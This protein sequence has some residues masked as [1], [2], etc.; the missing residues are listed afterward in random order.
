MQKLTSLRLE[1]LVSASLLKT[2][3]ILILLA[4]LSVNVTKAQ[5]SFAAAEDL[6]SAEWG[7]ATNVNIGVVPDT[8]AP[9]IAGT[10]PNAPLWYRWTAPVDG[11]VEMD[12]V[13]SSGLYTNINYYTFFD[14]NVVPP[15][16]VLRSNVVVTVEK[17]DTV[18]G[19]YTGNSVDTLSQIAANDDLFPLNGSDPQVNRSGNLENGGRYTFPQPYHGPSHLRFNAQGGVSYYFAVDSKIYSAG[20]SV[21]IG[22]VGVVST[23]KF[24]SAGTNIL[25]WAYKSSGIFRFATENQD[26]STGLPLYQAADTESLPLIGLNN[27]VNSTVLTYYQYNA[28]GVLVTVT[29][30]AGSTGRA[31]VNYTTVDGTDLPSLPG[32]DIPAF[33]GQDYTPVSGTLVFDDFE[34][35]KT[36]LIPIT[37]SKFFGSYSGQQYSKV[38]GI[39]LIDDDGATSPVLDPLESWE[40]SPPRVDPKFNLA[41]VQILSTDAD[42]Y[43]P[44]VDT[45]GVMTLAPTNAVFNFEKAC[46][47]VPADVNDTNTSPWTQVTVYVVRGGTNKEAATL[48]YRV[49]N[50]LGSDQDSGEEQNILFPL[51]PGS[52]Y[53]VPTPATWSPIR[54]TNSDFDMAKGTIS[55]P[56]NGN[57]NTFQPIQFSVPT[58][59]LTK[60]NKDFKIQLYREVNI[61]GQNEPRLVGMVNETTVTILFNDLNPPAGSV[62]ELYNADFN[63]ELAIYASQIPPTSPPDNPN[64]GVGL[65]GQVYSLALLPNNETLLG[66]DFASYN[67]FA[68]NNVA[69]VLTNGNLDTTF[70]S[71]TGANGAVNAVSYFGSQFYIGGDFTSYNGTLVGHVA[72][73]NVNGSLDATFNPGLG[74]DGTIRALTVLPNGE[75][76]IGGDFT[77]VNGTERNFLALLNTDGTLD[78][79]FDPASNLD[80]PVYTLAQQNGQFLVGGNFNVNGQIYKNIVRLNGD[81]S[82]DTTFNSGTGAN[83]LVR[84]F[85]RMPGGQIVVGGEFTQING[86]SL[87][88]IA[89]LNSD[90]SI[91][92]GF[93]IG[94]AADGPVFNVNYVSVTNGLT[95]TNIINFP[96]GSTNYVTNIFNLFNHYL[97][98]G[99]TF[100]S[101]NGTHRYG[102]TRLYLD[103]TVDTTFMDTAYNQF[104]G[105]KRIYSYDQPGV[106]ASAVQND[107]GVLIGGAFVQVGGGQANTNVCNTLDG[108]E[109]ITPSFGDT[110][111]W[112]EPKTRDG[113]RNRSSFA[114]LVGGATAGPGNIGL[115]QNSY[116]ANKSQTSLGISLVRTNGILGPVTA[117]FSVQTGTAQSGVDYAYASAPPMNWIAWEYTD[118]PSRVHSDGLFGQSG[119]LVDPYGL[120]L[121]ASTADTFLNKQSKVSISII[122]NKQT[123]GNLNA[124]FQLANPNI[125]DTFYL[126]GQNIPVGAALGASSATFTLVDDTSYPGQFGFSSPVFIATNLS[127][128]ISV[129]RSNGTFGVVSM[130]YSSSNGTAVVG[131]DYIG[132]TNKSLIFGANVTSNGFNVTVKN[133]GVIYTNMVEKTVN[134]RLFNIGTTPGA[135]FG[136]SNAV[137]RIINP[138]YQGYVTLGATNYS[139]ALSSGVLNFTVN[140]ISGSLGSVT[141]QYGTTNGSAIN[142]T[143]YVGSTNILTWNNGDVS[144]RVV[145]IPLINPGVVGPNKQ[146]GVKLFN[147][148]INGT[149]N[150]ALM[151]LIPNASLTISN[152]NNNGSIQFTAPSYL[153]NEDGGYATLTV[154]RTGG[155][156]GPIS[157]HYAT[158]DGPA[159]DG[160]NYTG[161]NGT[162]S[163]ASGQSSASFTVP[164]LNDGVPNPPPANFYFNVSLIGPGTSSSAVVQIADAQTVIHPP[165]SPDT[166]FITD[167]MNGNVLALALQ[168]NGQILAGGNFTAVGPVAENRLARL[169]ADG[170]LDTAFLNGLSGANAAVNT[171]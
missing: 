3:A 136:I 13:G 166:D 54:G 118:H 131:T 154:V 92:S 1:S 50:V 135:T 37:S 31:M 123:S 4:G 71:G 115:N 169:N 14:T 148:T 16:L 51:Q 72:R 155:A 125:A 46:Y 116:S 157:A 59:S 79:T 10:P 9:S 164:I 69:L 22:G 117:N 2:G 150:L 11:V 74:A 162:I 96:P 32:R 134:L 158:S 84:T 83:G 101:F 113:V 91:D 7:G 89:R 21:T 44:D 49:N 82:V 43:G 95:S 61:G 121:S 111:L 93:N 100:S 140:R 38:F 151:G 45:N 66:G 36:I 142:G 70:D 163:L 60:F 94:T 112:V 99:G 25:H 120:S 75:V 109:F 171:L 80:G 15:Q 23:L 107:G 90:G 102:F 85:A 145:S 98:V 88:H 160:I 106:F 76:L 144:P 5:D 27:D 40:V 42:P 68:R 147:P 48:N 165:G 127:P 73:L 128:N 137:L 139:G 159:V 30:S 47:R 129:V 34:M 132:L 146:F 64:P 24:A 86:V 170:S 149:P 17:L 8:G 55:F 143:D 152:D 41:M 20:S 87:N 57:G 12:T 119:F 28:P 141:V 138:N 161:T 56:A 18:L 26:A 39:K 62:D 126:G 58:S 108:E 65:Y 53:A 6:G 133:N 33:A 19:V 97:Y 77:H 35:S 122:N 153:V 168:P 67:G 110:N 81:G 63:S 103:G 78:T 130:M 105:L 167:G 104:A 29:R 52:D 114:R 124:Q 156:V